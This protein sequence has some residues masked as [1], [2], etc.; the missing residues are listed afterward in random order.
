M[1]LSP[2]RCSCCFKPIDQIYIIDID[3]NRYCSWDCT[4]KCYYYTN[5]YESNLDLY[6]DLFDQFETLLPKSISFQ[7]NRDYSLKQ[8]RAKLDKMV[9]KL[10][11]MIQDPDYR[12]V[13]RTKGTESCID[14]EIYSMLLL[15]SQEGQPLQNLLSGETIKVC[16]HCSI[17]LD[18]KYIVDQDGKLF[19]SDNCLEN[20][21]EENP[22]D[23][24]PHPYEEQ[25]LLVRSRYIN[26]LENWEQHLSSKVNSLEAAVDELYEEIDEI[27]GDYSDF[28]RSE[29]DDG[30]YAWE[31]YQYTQKLKDLQ[32][33]IFAWRPDRKTYYW[34][35]TEL[36]LY[37]SH[38]EKE[39]QLFDKIT[40]SL[41][42]DGYED[43]LIK[44]LKNLAHP[45][46]CGCNLLFNYYEDALEVYEVF[47]PYFDKYGVEINLKKAHRCEADCG[48]IVG[49][50]DNNLLLNGFF[51]CYSHSESGDYGIFSREELEKNLQYISENES[52]MMKIIDRDF[53]DPFKQMIKR[54]CRTYQ[55]EIPDWAC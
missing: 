20:F 13:L 3:L 48:D 37:D 22:A 29:G 35:S 12:E 26:I 10:D 31:I 50:N 16:V 32:Q 52:E 27:I 6:S 11:S 39:Q 49:S 46:H 51:Y 17:S 34:V 45:Y 47:K 30:V 38:D 42:L 15:L 54:S 53:D 36:G 4:E 55:L 28:I 41:Y 8:N 25:Y 43:D 14:A 21:L 7:E 2:D 19:C 18:E 24:E 9:R 44:I 40:A 33:T 23:F 5:P 1:Q